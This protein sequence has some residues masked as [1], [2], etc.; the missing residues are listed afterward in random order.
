MLNSSNLIY[1]DIISMNKSNIMKLNQFI[2]KYIYLVGFFIFANDDNNKNHTFNENG[3]EVSKEFCF[4]SPLI[5]ASNLYTIHKNSSQLTIVFNKIPNC[6][7]LRLSAKLKLINDVSELNFYDKNRANYM[8][9][10]V[11]DSLVIQIDPQLN[12]KLI[13][14]V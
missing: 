14:L 12:Y 8:S 1:C 13:L 4:N 5:K 3:T 7:E 9:Y 10:D 11:N 2:I 6:E